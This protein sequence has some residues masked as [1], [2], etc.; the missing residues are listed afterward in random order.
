MKIGSKI[1]ARYKISMGEVCEAATMEPGSGMCEP[2]DFPRDPLL[3]P[4]TCRSIHQM[5]G[6]PMMH[7]RFAL[8]SKV[9]GGVHWVKASQTNQAK[10]KNGMRRK[11]RN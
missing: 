8:R 3:T 11:K 4:S 5:P 7:Q 1:V 6:M 2:G 9:P 10:T